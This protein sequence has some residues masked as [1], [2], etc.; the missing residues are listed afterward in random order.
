MLTW[1]EILINQNSGTASSETET[2]GLG[3]MESVS[4]LKH[5]KE[6]FIK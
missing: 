1:F 4:L 5:K 3:S 2:N 6:T